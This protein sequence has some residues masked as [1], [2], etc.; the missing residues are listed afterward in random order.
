MLLTALATAAERATLR[1]QLER[2]ED[3]EIL[4]G[5]RYQPRELAENFRD[6]T[7]VNR[8]FGGSGTT[9]RHLER[10]IT[11]VSPHQTITILDLGTGV[12]DI[13]LAIASWARAR[14][15]SVAII[16]SDTSPD[17]LA[18]AAARTRD[19]PVIAIEQFDAR[20]VPLPDQSV[21][22]ALCSLALHHF[23]SVDAIRVLREMDRLSRLGFVVNDLRRC[24]SGYG[25][26]WAAS[27]LTTRNRLTRHDAP[28]SIR[29]AFTP[30]ELQD[31][32]EQAGI[33]GVSIAT[34][35]WFR[36]V[37]VKGG[38]HAA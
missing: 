20:Q 32:V 10:L 4:D 24:W 13:P 8:F 9:L 37:A 11:P 15:T 28:L 19:E 23:S 35:P 5:T 7:R 34:A 14:G 33:I 27:R 3:V 26:S 31:L 2:S 30:T 17:I 36:M 22:V 21:D 29:R 38:R 12:A 1:L 18:L 25:A 6:I 16:A